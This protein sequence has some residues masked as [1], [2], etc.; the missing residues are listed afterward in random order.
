MSTQPGHWLEYWW[1]K[2]REAATQAQ[3]ATSDLDR[4]VQEL[5]QASRS[6]DPY[7]DLP[8]SER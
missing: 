2:G 4:E 8:T 5:R 3:P 6:S 7:R 1:Q